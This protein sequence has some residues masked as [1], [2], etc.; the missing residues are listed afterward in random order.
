M[1]LQLVDAP[2]SSN[3][4][5]VALFLLSL[6]LCLMQVLWEVLALVHIYAVYS[7]PQQHILK[8]LKQQAK[9]PCTFL[10]KLSRM[11]AA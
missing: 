3:Y 8:P 10:E 9:G 2:L 5:Y 11:E 6:V 1:I 4:L 7:R